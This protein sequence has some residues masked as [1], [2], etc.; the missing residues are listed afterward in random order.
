MIK[1]GKYWHILLFFMVVCLM[2]SCHPTPITTSSGGAFTYLGERYNIKQARF[3]YMG[4]APEH[5]VP[6]VLLQLSSSTLTVNESTLSGYGALLNLVLL[7]DSAHA[8]MQG[9]F[10]VSNSWQTMT[11][12]AD[13]SAMIYYTQDKKDTLYTPIGG[14]YLTIAPIALG[15]QFDLHLANLAG[16]SILGSYHGETYYNSSIDG[17]SVGYMRIDTLNYALQQGN[18]YHWGELFAPGIYYY[19]YYLY[20]TNMRRTDKG[21]Y[22]YGCYLV[23]G[24]QSNNATLP[25]NGTYAVSRFY[26]SETLLY[27]HKSGNMNWGTFWQTYNKGSVSGRATIL[28]DSIELNYQPDGKCLIKIDLKDQMG[29]KVSGEYLGNFNN[30]YYP[31]NS[32]KE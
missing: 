17:D 22:S 5:N 10:L 29:N 6:V 4:I 2:A 21:K 25:L 3:E 31:I 19:E 18:L 26:E 20:S 23:L 11:V 1:V 16:D 15:K 30:Y 24:V 32:D 28:N 13:S 14:G 9:D 12:L 27:G 7:V 8:S